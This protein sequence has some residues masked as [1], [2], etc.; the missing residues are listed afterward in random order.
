MAENTITID[1]I[2][3]NDYSTEENFDLLVN[4]TSKGNVIASLPYHF[5][6]TGVLVRDKEN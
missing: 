4:A 1:P 6:F 2:N 5:K 3:F